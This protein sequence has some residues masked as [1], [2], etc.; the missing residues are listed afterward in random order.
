MII[1]K[2]NNK[3]ILI[4]NKIYNKKIIN[5]LKIKLVNKKVIQ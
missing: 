4:V 3:R 5:N 2:N 1:H